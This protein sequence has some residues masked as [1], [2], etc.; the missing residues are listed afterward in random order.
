MTVTAL[1]LSLQRFFDAN[2]FYPAALADLFPEFAPAGADGKPMS[3]PPVASDGFGY[4][5]SGKCDTL[6]VTLV[7]GETYAASSLTGP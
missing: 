7:S 2:G 6:T 5:G 1:R 3:A 4:R